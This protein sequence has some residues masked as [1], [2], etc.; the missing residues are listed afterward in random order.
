MENII[1]KIKH[2]KIVSRT[3]IMAFSL[4]LSAV[5]YNVFLLPMNL[6]TGG[7]NGIA[8]IT[9]YLYNIDPALMILFI[10]IACIIISLLYLDFEKTTGTIIASLMYP[11]FV[12]ITAPIAKIFVANTS[13]MFIIIIIAG[14]LSGIANGLMYKTGYSNGGLPV[15]CQVLYKYFKIPIA[16]S[17]LFINLVIVGTGSIFF[18]LTN[19]MY[20]IIFL[21]INSLVLDRVLLGI[22]KNKAFYII[23]T[24]E[25]VIKE[26]IID[27][28]KHSVTVFDVKGGFL[29]KK[30]RV[31]LTVIPSR[32]YYRVTEGIKL[33]DKEAFF[34][35]TD[36]YQVEGGK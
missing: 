26:Y 16:K 34:V 3:I 27:K 5:I 7:S 2:K 29:E 24:E 32:E 23:T 9:N 14:V 17:S 8:T 33:L 35:V 13:D 18:G 1:H 21:Y 30:K 31:L 15:I 20:A 22:S 28:L 12:E 11:L 6:V 4:L 25:K 19:A 36:A 10:S